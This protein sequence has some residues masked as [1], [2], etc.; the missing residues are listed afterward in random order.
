MKQIIQQYIESATKRCITYEQFMELALYHP[1]KGYYQK[2]ESKVGKKG[3]FITSPSVHPVFGRVLAGFLAE[4]AE[5]EKLPL[6]VCELGAGDG[7]LTTSILQE[8]ES[9]S[10]SSFNELSYFAVE[11]SRYH[12][13]LLKERLGK[14]KSVQIY[15]SLAA[16]IEAMPTFKGIVLSNE[17][18]DAL[19]VR[20]VQKVDGMLYE[21]MV[22]LTADGELKEEMRPCKDR[23][24][25]D[26]LK[27]VDFPIFEGERVE[28]PLAMTKM[29]GEL[30]DWIDFGALLTI[31][32]GYSNE[33]REGPEHKEGSLRGYCRHRLVKDPLLNPS[34]M[35][36]TAHLHWDAFN[37]IAAAEG[38]HSYLSISQREFLLKTGIFGFLKDLPKDC[39]PFSEA[40]RQ[41]R[42]I[43][44]LVSD[45]SFGKAFQVMLHGKG[46]QG[47]FVENWIARQPLEEAIKKDDEH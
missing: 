17:L 32:Y 30:A 14:E 10:P 11:T 43:V 6:N 33:E 41:N 38:F 47:D 16:L 3:D 31:D 36:L 42:A 34:E 27:R 2:S 19:P 21:V 44:E 5:E 40:R 15:G 37:Q 1:S 26:W 7:K 28:I 39:D 13:K 12:R 45:D 18:F 20:V 8:W 35:D 23:A 4:L 24:I 46:L 9:L 29:I 22:G 25:L